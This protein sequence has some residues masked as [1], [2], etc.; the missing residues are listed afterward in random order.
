MLLYLALYLVYD[1]IASH[2]CLRDLIAVLLIM[3]SA[4]DTSPY[5]EKP[6]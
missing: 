6:K 3:A 4:T 2:F 1:V 5:V